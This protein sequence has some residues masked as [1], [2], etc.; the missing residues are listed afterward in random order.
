MRQVA[1]LLRTVLKPTSKLRLRLLP[2]R[3]R[4]LKAM[5]APTDPA[6]Q[7][8]TTA[9]STQLTQLMSK[10]MRLYATK[11]DPSQIDAALQAYKEY[12]SLETD[13]AKK[14]K[15]QLD[16]AQML[17]DA[18]SAEKAFAEFQSILATQPDNPDANLGAGLSLYSTGDKNKFQEAANYLQKFVDVAPDIK[19]KD[20]AKQS[21]N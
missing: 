12:I 3:L 9:T 11:A 18:G 5:P 8:R 14:S 7:T 1:G 10:S 13:P 6:E 15:A 4:L 2:K 17:L 20:D 16:M 21:C 19:M